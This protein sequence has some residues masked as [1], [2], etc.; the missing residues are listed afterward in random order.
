MY[1]KDFPS[2]EHALW[3]S[4]AIGISPLEMDDYYAGK[5]VLGHADDFPRMLGVRRFDDGKISVSVSFGGCHYLCCLYP[6]HEYPPYVSILTD[7]SRIVGRAPLVHD[8]GEY[9]RMV[10][11]AACRFVGVERAERIQP[12]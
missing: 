12:A 9:C 10:A 7:Y 2:V 5:Y 6:G 3:Y 11:D 4:R 8:R 1:Q